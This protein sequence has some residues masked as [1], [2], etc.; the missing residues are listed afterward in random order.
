MALLGALAGCGG[1]GDDE[2]G[3]LTA[4]SLSAST[5]TLSGG[6]VGGY[7]AD[8]Y[9]YGGAAPYRLDNTFPDAIKV[10]NMPVPV[11]PAIPAFEDVTT[12]T[13]VAHR[14]DRFSVWFK[15]GMC[16]SPGVVV[17]VDKNDRQVSLT[18]NHS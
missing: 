18:L 10:S 5:L 15:P 14:G 3:S 7:V 16:F 17:V 2:A 8:V 13:E 1:G 11:D 9:V 12:T 4:F 6:C